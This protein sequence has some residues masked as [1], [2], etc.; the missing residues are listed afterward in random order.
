L[1]RLFS[2]GCSVKN[3]VAHQALAE[4]VKEV[5]AIRAAPVAAEELELAKNYMAGS[6]ARSLEAPRTLARFALNAW[7]ND[8]PEDH[9]TTWLQ[10]LAAVTQDDVRHAAQRFL[11]PD[12]AVLLVVGDAAQVHEGLAGVASNGTVERFD[13]DGEPVGN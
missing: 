2:A 4:I 8:L 6:F 13:P 11:H 1:G 3:A 5:R 12:R 7:L 9:Y 10:R